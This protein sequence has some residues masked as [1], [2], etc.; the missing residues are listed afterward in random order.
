MS[1]ADP[2]RTES[3]PCGEVTLST[4]PIINCINRLVTATATRTPGPTE[5]ARA[6]LEILRRR[7]VDRPVAV[8]ATLVRNSAGKRVAGR[9]A[10]GIRPGVWMPAATRNHRVDQG[11]CG[12]AWFSSPWARRGYNR[13]PFVRAGFR[14][15]RMLEK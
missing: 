2:K 10:T 14:H 13:E 11:R 12:P 15:V 7:L 4:C 6:P 8:S 9:I 1:A 5:I 3:A